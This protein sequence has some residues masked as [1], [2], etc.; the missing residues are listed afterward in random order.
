MVELVEHFFFLFSLRCLPWPSRGSSAWRCSS[1]SSRQERRKD[2][3]LNCLRL[4]AARFCLDFYFFIVLLIL[5]IWVLGYFTF[6]F[7]SDTLKHF[8]KSNESCVFTARCVPRAILPPA[9]AFAPCFSEHLPLQPA[10]F[11][12]FSATGAGSWWSRC[13]ACCDPGECS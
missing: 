1:P 8:Q 10:R 7:S 2:R 6:F 13:G 9:G 11:S 12:A 3:T 5:L 4:W